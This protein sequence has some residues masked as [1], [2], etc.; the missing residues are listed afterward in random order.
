MDSELIAAREEFIQGMSRISHFWGF[1]KAMGAILPDLRSSKLEPVQSYLYPSARVSVE[2]W[3]KAAM[4][5]P[6]VIISALIL[7]RKNLFQRSAP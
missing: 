6:V 3:S 1:P 2:M 7:L 4:A 5:W